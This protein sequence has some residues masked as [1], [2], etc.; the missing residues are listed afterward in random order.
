MLVESLQ[1]IQESLSQRLRLA[2]GLNKELLRDLPLSQLLTA[3][4][5][6]SELNAAAEH[7]AAIFERLA[8]QNKLLLARSG[9]VVPATLRFFPLPEVSLLLGAISRD[10]SE[11]LRTALGASLLRSTPAHAAEIAA[12]AAAVFE[13]GSHALCSHAPIPWPVGSW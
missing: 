2:E 9:A 11:I 6:T 1:E 4:A 8:N 12:A 5:S 3:L 10:M 7:L 13:V